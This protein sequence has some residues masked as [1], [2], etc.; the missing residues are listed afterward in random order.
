M[1]SFL[2]EKT[3]SHNGFTLHYYTAGPAENDALVFLHPAFGDHRCFHKQV[4]FFAK[5][6]HIILLDMPGHGKSQPGKNP[7]GIECTADFLVQILAGEGHANCHIVGVSLGS[8]IAQDFAFRFPAQ[9]K[10]LTVVG[11]YSIFGD[12]RSVQ[13]AQGGE[14]L[15]W[16]LMVLFSMERFRRYVARTSVL[17][18]EGQETFY[19][20]MQ[21]FKRGSFRVLA[22][23]GQVLRPEERS[24]PQPLLIACGDHDLPLVQRVAEA[25]QRKEPNSR[26]Q[27]IRDAGHCAN[28]DNAAQFN[29]VLSEFIGKAYHSP[30]FPAGRP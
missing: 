25:W 4:A 14:M 29:Q 23:M 22:G 6:Y 9:A 10:T 17:Y 12:N 1:S 21:H 5:D 2:I 7:V 16:F 26:F 8:L 27:G 15:K 24:C 19:Q 13:R 3:I 28:M 11:G 20:A 18:P 30:I